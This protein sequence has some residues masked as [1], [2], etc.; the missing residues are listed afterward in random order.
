[1]CSSDRFGTFFVVILTFIKLRFFLPISAP[2]AK[3][4]PT[5]NTKP[6]VDVSSVHFIQNICS[7]VKYPKKFEVG[8]NC[9]VSEEKDG[10]FW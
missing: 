7:L 3:K 1:M 6:P 8:M 5:P 10:A 4:R 9:L 2:R